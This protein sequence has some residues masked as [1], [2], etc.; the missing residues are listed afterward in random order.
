MKIESQSILNTAQNILKVQQSL[1]NSISK[2]EKE[3]GGIDQSLISQLTQYKRKLYDSQSQLTQLQ[4]TR[5]GLK[6]LLDNLANVKVSGFDELWRH[7]SAIAE[8]WDNQE[9]PVLKNFL[10]SQLD[11]VNTIDN[12][13]ITTLRKALSDHLQSV[14][15]N[16]AAQRDNIVKIQ[17][18][19]ENWQAAAIIHDKSITQMIADIHNKADLS[20]ILTPPEGDKIRDLLS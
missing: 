16:I 3:S 5:E 2:K 20:K 10:K 14:E 7:V 15:D 4:M 18:S 12:S 19:G 1:K 17:V 6:E 9:E 8:K 13:V 11:S